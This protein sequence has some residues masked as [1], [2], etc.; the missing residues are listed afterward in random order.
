MTESS[1]DL[2][3]FACVDKHRRIEQDDAVQHHVVFQESTEMMYT[4]LLEA[5]RN[6]GYEVVAFGPN[7]TYDNPIDDDVHALMQIDT[8]NCEP[9]DSRIWAVFEETDEPY[10]TG[11]WAWE[12][13]VPEWVDDLPV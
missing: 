4:Q 9:T 11:R 7:Y 3:E 8:V 10:R 12:D 2:H 5:I 1:T 13:D 6:E